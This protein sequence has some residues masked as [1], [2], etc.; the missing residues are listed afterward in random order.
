[1][2]DDGIG[3]AFASGERQLDETHVGL[4][5][6]SERA[7]RIGARLETVSTPGRGTSVILTLPALERAA[8]ANHLAEAGAN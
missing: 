6:M 8:P 7:E 3:F 5:I 4:R 1:M 2:R